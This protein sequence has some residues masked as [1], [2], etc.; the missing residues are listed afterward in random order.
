[1]L[2]GIIMKRKQLK[3]LISA[4]HIALISLIGLGLLFFDFG[5]AHANR[6][7][8]QIATS[9]LAVKAI[10]ISTNEPTP[11]A[12]VVNTSASSQSNPQDNVIVLILIT[13]LTPHS[14]NGKAV[15]GILRARPA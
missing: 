2:E 3:I 12:T 5:V 7:V 6:Q 4:A 14:R 9:N 1:M 10:G 13:L 8:Y 15:C 11:Q